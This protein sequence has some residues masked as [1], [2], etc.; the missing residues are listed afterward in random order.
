MS[1]TIDLGVLAA[2]SVDRIRFTVKKDGTL[3]TN[4]DSVVF[5]F[6]KP[7]R[8]TQF[9]R[10]AV[11]AGDG[12]WYYDTVVGDIP[13]VAASY[14]YWTVGVKVTDG[15]IVKWYPHEIGFYVGSQP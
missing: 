10:N 12:V 5:R 15:G 3:W 6:E 11:D 9:D 7:D 1:T 8:D 2:A 4:I 14:G 13:D